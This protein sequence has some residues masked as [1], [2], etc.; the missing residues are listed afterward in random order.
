MRC[1]PSKGNAV[2]GSPYSNARDRH[3]RNF[4][5]LLK[6]PLLPLPR[7]PPRDRGNSYLRFGKKRRF[8]VTGSFFYPDTSR[9]F[10]VP[11]LLDGL[12]FS[13]SQNLGSNLSRARYIEEAA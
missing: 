4:L 10:L 1:S 13:S 3:D 9:Y 5:I 6:I 11:Y 7:Y 2:T 8:T 12:R